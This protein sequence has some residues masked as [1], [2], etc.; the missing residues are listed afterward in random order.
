MKAFLKAMLLIPLAIVFVV[1]AVANRHLVTVAFDP[2]N[3]VNPSL[4]LTLP[5]FV[6]LILTAISG[7]IA[8]GVATWFGQGRWRRAARRA[9]ADA[10]DARAEVAA[11]RA[12]TDRRSVAMLPA[13]PRNDI[14][15]ST[16]A[17]SYYP[18][19]DRRD[20]AV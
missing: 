9:E 15:R 8:G 4:G 1:F 16:G 18:A 6:V 13:T 11:L 10:R 3:T 19:R 14:A 12:D 7:V 2:F 17:I 5:L 20:A